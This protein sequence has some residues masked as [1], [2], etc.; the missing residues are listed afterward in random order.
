MTPEEIEEKALEYFTPLL[1]LLNDFGG[2]KKLAV[3]K[4]SRGEKANMMNSLVESAHHAAI[5]RMAVVRRVDD[6][7]ESRWPE[8]DF[9]EFTKEKVRGTLATVPPYAYIVV[10]ATGQEIDATALIFARSVGPVLDACKA[11]SKDIGCQEPIQLPLARDQLAEAIG[12][13]NSPLPPS[14]Q[15]IAALGDYPLLLA[16]FKSLLEISGYTLNSDDKV[17]DLLSCALS[18]QFLLF[19][20][21]SGSGKSFAGKLLSNLFQKLVGTPSASL[22]VRM[23]WLGPEEVGGYPPISSED[24][25]AWI[26]GPLTEK[27]NEGIGFL[28]VD[29]ANL[30]KI[31]GY[32]NPVIH[33]LSEAAVQEIEWTPWPIPGQKHFR[34][35]PRIVATINV[36]E[37][38]DSPSRKV[39]ARAGVAVF[40]SECYISSGFMNAGLTTLK[41]STQVKQWMAEPVQRKLYPP[42]RALELLPGILQPE[43][44]VDS[45]IPDGTYHLFNSIEPIRQRLSPRAMER[46]RFYIAS[47]LLLSHPL[48]REA[49]NNESEMTLPT[50][51]CLALC[52]AVAHFVIP[53][54][55]P[56]ELHSLI[57]SMQRDKDATRPSELLQDWLKPEW[58]EVWF[59][60]SAMALLI[61][62]MASHMRDPYEMP[63]FWDCMS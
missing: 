50:R 32:L 10:N 57:Q 29:E 39:L 35:Y 13:C 41:K 7:D 2:T 52:N 47:Y 21:P 33:G 30:S 27:L 28:L 4:G 19:A 16:E 45:L 23:G 11:L 37:N 9:E 15:E 1:P 44:S 60:R 5:C 62:R 43:I 14:S 36:D 3:R 63:S 56:K 31:E 18:T 58:Q 40:E 20:G 49:V 61:S 24:P 46:I 12:I 38:S 54:M 34:S 22:N 6:N 55:E 17:L 42:Q 26:P 53:L 51:A 48:T 8:A 25:E 59:L